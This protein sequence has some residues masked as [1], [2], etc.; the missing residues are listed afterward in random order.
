M[1]VARRHRRPGLSLG[2]LAIAALAGMTSACRQDM[3]NQAKYKPLRETPFFANLMTS[4]PLLP[5]TVAR[6]QLH[7]D[8]LLNT[9]RDGAKPADMFPFPITAEVLNRGRERFNIYCTP[10]HAR[11]GDGRGMIV[12]RGLKQPPSFHE[13]RL[14][15]IAPGYFFN[16]IT[17]GFGVMPSYAAQIP[18]ND[19]WAIISYVRALQLSRNAN[20]ADLTTAEKA[21][22]TKE[23]SGG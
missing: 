11:T 6:G 17:N 23:S 20:V 22:L 16:V 4:R 19:R 14:R 12:Q 3:H 21:E 5:G 18:V 15:D 2:L 7:E 13:Q 8:A 9:G 10:C 1:T